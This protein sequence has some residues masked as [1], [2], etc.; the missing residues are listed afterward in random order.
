MLRR[1]M[2]T[3]TVSRILGYASL[4]SLPSRLR[5]RGVPRDGG[6]VRGTISGPKCCSI[7]HELTGQIGRLEPFCDYQ[8]REKR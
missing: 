1:K 2:A 6:L 8:N 7:G 5:G 3:E 4:S